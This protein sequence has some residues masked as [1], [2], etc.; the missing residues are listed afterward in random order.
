MEQVCPL[1]HIISEVG[2]PEKQRSWEI[3]NLHKKTDEL[4]ETEVDKIKLRHKCNKM[5]DDF[6]KLKK[7]EREKEQL[8]Q[9]KK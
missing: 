5:E 3:D 7:K 2:N 1:E 8:I 4:N 9:T 6:N